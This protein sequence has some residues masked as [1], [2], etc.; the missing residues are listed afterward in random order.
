MQLSNFSQ[1]QVSWPCFLRESIRLGQVP[2]HD[3]IHVD[4]VRLCLRTEPPAGL[5]FIHQMICKY[6][7]P[8]WNDIDMGKTKELR[9]EPVPLLLCPTWTDPGVC[10]ERPVTNCL[11]HGMASWQF[12]VHL[13]YGT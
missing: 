5:F 3:V 4:G 2:V 13:C 11:S 1:R 9:E 12:M 7:E 10:G 6:G 8:R